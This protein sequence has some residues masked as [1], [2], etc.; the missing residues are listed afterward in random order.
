MGCLGKFFGM[1]Q[2]P[3]CP[4]IYCSTLYLVTGST[5]SPKKVFWENFIVTVFVHTRPAAEA[6]FGLSFSVFNTFSVIC[7]P[8]IN[9]EQCQY[10]VE[11]LTNRF[12]L[13]LDYT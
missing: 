2:L 4:L 3:N 5:R 1:S 13:T 8:V 6:D 12:M 11:V 7:F 9:T 10:A